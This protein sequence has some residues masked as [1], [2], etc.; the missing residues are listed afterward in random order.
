MQDIGNVMGLT[1]LAKYWYNGTRT[2][3]LF[4]YGVA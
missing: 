1:R 3:V 2:N 4:H